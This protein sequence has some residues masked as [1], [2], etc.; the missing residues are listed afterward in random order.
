MESLRRA[1]CRYWANSP[2][3]SRRV[4]VP[5][6]CRYSRSCEF[7]RLRE[8]KRSVTMRQAHV[9]GDKLFGDY[10]GDTAPVIV[11]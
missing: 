11:G 2:T 7:Y 9:G 6:G 4:I 8:S 10:A 1:L 3:T 5:E